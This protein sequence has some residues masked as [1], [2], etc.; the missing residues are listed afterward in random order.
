MKKE[1]T[2]ND[3]LEGIVVFIDNFILSLNEKQVIASKLLDAVREHKCLM[4]DISDGESAVPIYDYDNYKDVQQK[5]VSIDDYII[6]T[7]NNNVLKGNSTPNNNIVVNNN[8]RFNLQDF[9]EKTKRREL[10]H[11]LDCNVE[12]G[13]RTNTG[14]VAVGMIIK[15]MRGN[16]CSSHE[17]RTLII[18]LLNNYCKNTGAEITHFSSILKKI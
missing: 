11:F 15:A 8:S 12:K 10:I 13:N 2:L 7:Q 6:K 5:K 17:I 1:L 9:K 18:D 14:I 4:F 16:N 3:K